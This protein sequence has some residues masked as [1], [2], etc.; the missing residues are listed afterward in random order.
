MPEQMLELA[1]L[2]TVAEIA[3]GAKDRLLG[4]G[5]HAPDRVAVAL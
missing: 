5:A 3:E 4:H 1:S 2:P